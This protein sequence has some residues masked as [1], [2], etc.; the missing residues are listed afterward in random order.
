VGNIN[1][2]VITRGHNDDDEASIWRSADR[3]DA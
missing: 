3:I 1:M 2:I